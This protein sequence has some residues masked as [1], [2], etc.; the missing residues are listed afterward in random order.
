MTLSTPVAE[1]GLSSPPPRELA[2]PA[3]RLPALKAAA[4]KPA[5]CVYLGLRDATN[6]RNFA[7]FNFDEVAIAAGIRYARKRGCKVFL[8]ANGAMA[9]GP[10]CP[11]WN[12][13]QAR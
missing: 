8:A 5:S 2:C 10:A 1:P 11:A 13:S 4:D 6:A 3:G 12:R 9:M 7:I